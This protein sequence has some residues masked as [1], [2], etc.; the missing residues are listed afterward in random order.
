MGAQS[1]RIWCVL[2][3]VLRTVLVCVCWSV[4]LIATARVWVRIRSNS[5]QRAEGEREWEDEWER[6]G[7]SERSS[8]E[9][10]LTELS[11]LIPPLRTFVR[12]WHCIAMM[13]MSRTR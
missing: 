6:E 11:A 8:R 2:V 10:Q 13:M 1:E 12:V 4:G 9:N 5:T 3:C 7:E